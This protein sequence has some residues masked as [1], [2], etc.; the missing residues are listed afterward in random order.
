MSQRYVVIVIAI[1]IGL[2]MSGRRAAVLNLT[3]EGII[4]WYRSILMASRG[5]VVKML[6]VDANRALVWDANREHAVTQKRNSRHREEGDSGV[7]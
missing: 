1:A 4:K 2:L 5:T 7:Q 3:H 6:T